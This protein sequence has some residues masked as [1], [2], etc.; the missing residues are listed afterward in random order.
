MGI[1]TFL[2]GCCSGPYQGP[3]SDHFDGRRFF[4]P[5]KPMDKSFAYFV[6]WR[7]TAEPQ[8]WLEYREIPAYHKPPERVFCDDFNMALMWD[9]Q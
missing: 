5:S 8:Y 1:L 3:A 9:F 4:N 7:M 2:L 6:T